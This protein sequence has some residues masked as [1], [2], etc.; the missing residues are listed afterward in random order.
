MA[1]EVFQR[2]HVRS[3]SPAISITKTGR[4]VLNAAATRLVREMKINAVLLLWDREERKFAIRKADS[5][6]PHAYKVRF[7]RHWALFGARP[8]LKHIGWELTETRA[9]PASWNENSK[10]FEVKLPRKRP[11]R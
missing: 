11:I 1:Y 8:F 9:L 6:D 7:Q 5:S 3:E 2:K 10:M 4:I